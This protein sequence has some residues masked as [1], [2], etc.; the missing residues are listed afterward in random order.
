MWGAIKKTINSNLSKP[1]DLLIKEKTKRFTKLNSITDSAKLVFQR[2]TTGSLAIV[3]SMN[4]AE[5]VSMRFEYAGTPGVIKNFLVTKINAFWRLE[6]RV[7]E[8][9]DYVTVYY[10]AGNI[11]IYPKTV[12]ID[13][14][15]LNITLDQWL[16]L[17]SYGRENLILQGIEFDNSFLIECDIY[18]NNNKNYKINGHFYNAGIDCTL[19]FQ[20]QK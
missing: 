1:L 8:H 6:G 5:K 13:G 3:T 7:K 2:D 20:T 18:I 9:G 15:K 12:I 16:Y 11:Y 17:Q 4:S 14:V 10:G 19:L